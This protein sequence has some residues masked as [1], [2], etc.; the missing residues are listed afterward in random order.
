[1]FAMEASTAAD[2]RLPYPFFRLG[3]E[4]SVPVIDD[5]FARDGRCSS[6]EPLDIDV[7]RLFLLHGAA[8][9]PLMTRGEGRGVRSAM[10]ARYGEGSA[11]LAE[12]GDK[13]EEPILA[14][15]RFDRNEEPIADMLIEGEIMK[16]CGVD[17]TGVSYMAGGCWCLATL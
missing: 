9:S 13:E 14:V 8:E 16:G 5:A 4:L 7:A 15:E 11:E 1:M 12:A 2:M 17:W 6:R 3:G 10:A